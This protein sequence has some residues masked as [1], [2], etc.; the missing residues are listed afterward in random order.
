MSQT[1][2][3]L[4]AYAKINWTLRVL[5]RRADGLHEIETVF[6][7]ISLCDHL[8]FEVDASG[9]LGLSSNAP[10]MPHDGENLVIKAALAL[11]AR[12]GVRS[13]VRVHLRKSIPLGGGLGGG[14][15]NAA[16]T[17]LALVRLW[18]L[19]A[20]RAELAE[21]GARLGADVPFFLVGGT[22]LGTGT[23]ASIRPL[24]DASPAR[25]LI[26][27]PAV[28]IA[29]GRAYASLNAPALTTNHQESKLT[30]LRAEE[31]FDRYGVRSLHNDFEATIFA[32]EPEIKR[33][34]D[35]LLVAGARGALMTGSGASV[36][37][38]FDNQE[39]LER[40][41]QLTLEK[42]VGWRVFPCATVERAAYQEAVGLAMLWPV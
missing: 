18:G 40:A 19:D 42:E 36:F 29:T 5:G 25:V 2:L 17:L 39:A 9:R 4:P 6:R 1:S 3:T 15:S 23:G 28:R 41:H 8:S 11:R 27:T 10:D 24:A 20:S 38:L 35:A 14:S 34:R 30:V 12:F 31:D 21:I 16:V 13:G 22:A 32:A 26:V 37:G 7:T 33:A